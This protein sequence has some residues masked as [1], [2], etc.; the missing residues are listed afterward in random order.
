MLKTS[1][2]SKKKRSSKHERSFRVTNGIF[3][4]TDCILTIKRQYGYNYVISTY[5]Y[6][7]TSSACTYMCLLQMYLC[8]WQKTVF[9][10]TM[11]NIE[12]FE[13]LYRGKILDVIGTKVLRVFLLAIHS[14]HSPLLTNLHSPPPP[15]AKVA[16]NWFVTKTLYTETSSLRTPKIMPRKTSTKLYVDEF[17]FRLPMIGIVPFLIF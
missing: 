8:R 6:R 12:Y 11:Y 5:L 9:N 13:W 3:L 7:C 14:H 10:F 17:G 1:V 4:R 2:A 15:P 16:W